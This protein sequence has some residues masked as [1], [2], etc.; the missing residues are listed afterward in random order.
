MEA[1]LEASGYQ[2]IVVDDDGITR[3]D[4]EPCP[5]MVMSK[6][7]KADKMSDT[8]KPSRCGIVFWEDDQQ[9]LNML[10]TIDNDGSRGT[11][12]HT[13]GDSVF[14]RP[15]A[16]FELT[17]GL[18]GKIEFYDRRDEITYGPIE[19]LPPE[20]VIVAELVGYRKDHRAIYL[21]ERGS[22]LADGT[23]AAGRRVFFG[24][25]TNTFRHLSPSGQRLFDAAVAW[26][27]R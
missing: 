14:V 20:A 3:P 17:T 10:A 27:S 6:T 24:L 11:T 19:D 1:H 9:Q 16:P 5:V 13:P 15:D 21:Y 7:V 18:S 8:L 23:A 26:A 4:E 22:R 25:Y 2:V 12:W